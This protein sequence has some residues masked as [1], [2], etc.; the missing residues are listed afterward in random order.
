MATS[1]KEQ[2]CCTAGS[3]RNCYGEAVRLLSR[4][5]A[6][7]KDQPWRIIS[8]A[9]IVTSV[10]LVTYLV[11]LSQLSSYSQQLSTI[12]TQAQGENLQRAI[13]SLLE[14][15]TAGSIALASYISMSNTTCKSLKFNMHSISQNIMANYPSVSR[16]EVD[17]FDIVSPGGY[18][19]YPSFTG[20]S[21]GYIDCNLLD[22]DQ[23]CFVPFDLTKELAQIKTRK[24]YLSGPQQVSDFDNILAVFV[25]LPVW[26]QATGPTDNFNCGFTQ[27]TSCG[28]SCYDSSTGLKYFGTA[29]S[30]INV[31]PLQ[32]GSFAAYQA[33]SLQ[34]Y[35][36]SLA[37]SS[38][39]DDSDYNKALEG[40]V[41]YSTATAKN[42]LAA[43]ALKISIQSH[44][45]HWVLRI[46]P[47][48]GWSPSWVAPVNAVVVIACLFTGLVVLSL[49]LLYQ[50]YTKLLESML[51]FRVIQHRRMHDSLY[52]ESFED[53]TLFFCDIVD[54]TVISSCLQPLQVVSLLDELYSIFD[55]IAVD[56]GVYKV[57]TIG[58]CYFASTN[59]P[60]VE[61]GELAVLRMVGFSQALLEA[62]QRFRPVELE[63]KKGLRINVRIGIHT[64]PIVA[65]V[66][67]RG[68]P[69]WCYF[70]DTV[71]TASRMESHGEPMRIHMS[72]YSAKLL[73]V[74]DPDLGEK[75]QERSNLFVKGKGMMKTHFL[76]VLPKPNVPESIEVEI[77]P[78]QQEGQ[79]QQGQQQGQGG[80]NGEER[81]PVRV[82][83]LSTLKPS[84]SSTML[85]FLGLSTGGSA[86]KSSRSRTTDSGSDRPA[87]RRPPVRAT[88]L[89]AM[90]QSTSSSMLQFLGLAQGN[91][92]M[93]ESS[94]ASDSVNECPPVPADQKTEAG[95]SSG[96]STGYLLGARCLHWD[97]DVALVA[98]RKT[99]CDLVELYFIINGSMA[100]VNVSLDTLKNFVQAVSKKY[101]ENR[102]HNWRHAVFVA[103]Y[104]FKLIAES[105]PQASSEQVRPASCPSNLPP[106]V[107]FALLVSALVHDADHPGN[108]NEYEALT[109]SELAK[110]HG[111]KSILEKHH[112]EVAHQLMQ[113][114]GCNILENFS[115][116]EKKLFMLVMH[117]SIMS[118]DMSVHATL[119][120]EISRWADVSTDDNAATHLDISSLDN[121][122][123]MCRALLHAADLSSCV[124]QFYVAS[125]WAGR[126]QDEFEAQK[127]RL[128]AVGINTS[129]LGDFLHPISGV[130]HIDSEV[131]FLTHVARPMWVALG[132][133]WPTLNH[134]VKQI[135]ENL[136]EY[137]ELRKKEALRVSVVGASHTLP[138][139]SRPTRQPSFSHAFVPITTR[140]E[141]GG[142]ESDNDW[143]QLVEG[144]GDE[145]GSGI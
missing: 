133:L 52:S 4:S 95:P 103:H 63:D 65:G 81:P 41:I 128:A 117:E 44:N 15:S 75:L 2:S 141:E 47:K 105:A 101:R 42:P 28:S 84:V 85:Q 24:V 66:V 80:A 96:V 40:T 115:E 130:D 43:D 100:S 36:F 116:S 118:T 68:M 67:G 143:G 26:K 31:T 126:I 51:P 21:L 123:F 92:S 29:G 1:E 120:A 98:D 30:T 106:L 137:A 145:W 142:D 138:T 113:K 62:V 61:S 135:D 102:F 60:H 49:S 119:T 34:P 53:V 16:L 83:N 9:A 11:L 59:C 12:A 110:R 38:N 58:D 112:L 121:Q 144:D 97:F 69:R 127:R 7:T 57:E 6:L 124:R 87:K 107:Q 19:V 17:V 56:H 76:D 86:G 35:V 8:P 54:Y 79:Q 55:A 20:S 3:G 48:A 125:A 78:E 91:K 139:P 104:T 77:E 94:V 129:S 37:V 50:T 122:L 22:V 99:L 33:A 32:D 23:Q 140:I 89:S 39:L 132:R 14:Q 64:G 46:A 88:N 70:G 13:E 82:T 131:G 72:D 90:K 109:Q 108:T 74:A 27:P 93:S 18:Y 111:P 45:L 25:L 136:R 114:P 73:R 5:W 134:L 10:L 71:N